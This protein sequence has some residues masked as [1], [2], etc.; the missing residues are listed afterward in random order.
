VCCSICVEVYI[1]N[2]NTPHAGF[3]APRGGVLQCVAVWCSVVRYGAMCCG[4]LQ[5][6]FSHRYHAQ[7]SRLLAA[8]FCSVMQC[9]AVWCSV[10]RC[11]AVYTL[12][13]ILHTGLTA[14][15]SSVLQYAAV[16]CSMV[17]YGA[18]YCGMSQYT[19]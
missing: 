4:V 15:R 16:C 11:V 9:G 19:C 5:Y 1:L 2:L 3:A 12:A 8:V 14:P 10:L 6:I 17:Q 7:V 13:K 18:V